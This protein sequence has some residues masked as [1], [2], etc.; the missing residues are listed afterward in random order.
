VNQIQAGKAPIHL[1]VV[2]L[3]SLLW[4]GM[5]CTDYLMIRLRNMEWIS[6]TPEVDPI[7]MLTWVDSFP[8]WAQLGWGLAVWTGLGGSVLLLMRRRWAVPAFA[9]SLVGTVAGIAN[10][11][12]GPRPPAPLAEGF[13]SYMPVIIFAIASGLYY[14][15]NRQ[16]Q[17]GRLR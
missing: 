6:Q 10:Q 8:I 5:G 3:L 1:W 12:F 9:L 11:F 15:A 4:N 14:Y 7:A 16:K 13:M 17:A 2:G